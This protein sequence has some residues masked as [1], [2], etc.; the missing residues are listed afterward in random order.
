MLELFLNSENASWISVA[1]RLIFALLIFL[2][3]FKNRDKLSFYFALFF[4]FFGIEGIMR[5]FAFATGIRHLYFA[6][7]IFFGISALMVLQGVEEV[8]DDWLKKYYVVYAAG[9]ALVLLAA[10][11][12]YFIAGLPIGASNQLSLFPFYAVSGIIFLLSAYYLNFIDAKD[13]HPGDTLT[14]GGLVLLGILNFIVVP[15]LSAGLANIVLYAS[16]ISSSL[17]GLGW[18]L[19]IYKK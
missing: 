17:F 19:H 14:V 9:T 11:N 2:I 12:T 16:T 15:L 1:I 5:N 18:L 13:P 3:Y 10:Y 6:D 4:L 8:W 7:L